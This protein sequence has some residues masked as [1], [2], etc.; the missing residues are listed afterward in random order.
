MTA[1]DRLAWALA[2]GADK[3]QKAGILVR[4]LMSAI[5]SWLGRV[6]VKTVSVTYAF[7]RWVMGLF[8]TTVASVAR[9]A[10]DLVN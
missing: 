3:I 9:L 8:Y 4:N 5:L 10:I 7:I 1:L 2:T 6:V